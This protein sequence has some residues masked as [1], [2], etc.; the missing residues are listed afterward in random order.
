MIGRRAALKK[1]LLGVASLFLPACSEKIPIKVGVHPWIGYESLQLAQDLGYF[2]N[3]IELIRNASASS[4]IESLANGVIDAGALTLDEVL[5]LL[6]QGT[7]L[8]IV[9]VFDISAGADKLIS[10]DSIRTLGDLRGKR[11]AYEANTVGSLMLQKSLQLAGLRLEDVIPVDAAVG[12][13]QVALWR[14]EVV[15]A[16]ITYEPT[17]SLLTAESARVLL[18]SRDFPD[19]IFDVLAVRTDRLPAIQSQLKQLIAGHFSALQYIN[20]NYG[21]AIH[22]I[23]SHQNIGYTEVIHSIKGIRLPNRQENCRL[24]QLGS[25]LHIAANEVQQIMLEKG[26]LKQSLEMNHLTSNRFC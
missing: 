6:D 1:S 14:N 10:R 8:T 24:L 23:A 13:E 9:L 17:A 19:M 12:E 2:R 20:V 11:I 4:T 25:R 22:R 15:D 5:T 18:D 7:D 26:L 21:D 3:N 16:V